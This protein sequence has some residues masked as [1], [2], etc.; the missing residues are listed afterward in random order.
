[1]RQEFLEYLRLDE[2]QRAQTRPPD[3]HVVAN[4]ELRQAIG[5]LFQQKCAFCESR[6]PKLTTYRFRPTSEALPL[7]R[8]PNN[9]L[10][11]GWLADA[12]QNLYLICTDCIP[13]PMN[14]FPVVGARCPIPDP[15]IYEEYVSENSGD[16]R[17]GIDEKPLLL[18]PC[19]DQDIRSH[20]EPAMDGT[21]VPQ[22]ARGEAMIAHFKLNRK[23]LVDRRRR[24]FEGLLRRMRGVRYRLPGPDDQFSGSLRVLRDMYME[25]T[26]LMGGGRQVPFRRVAEAP[27]VKAWN[28]QSVEIQSFKSLEHVRIDMPEQNPEN[29]KRDY[30][31]GGGALL[32]LGENATGKSSLLEALALAMLPDDARDALGERPE[33]IILDPRYLGNENKKA[34][35]RGHVSLAFED[36][37]GNSLKRQLSLTQDGFHSDGLLPKGFPV[38]GYGAY[39]QYR[40]GQRRWTADRRVVSLFR[41]DNLL[42]NPERWL[43]RLPEDRFDMVVQALRYIIGEDFKIIERDRAS[44][45]C[46][47]LM[48]RD[49]VELRMPLD[50]VSSGFRT[51]LALTCDVMR[52]LM[53]REPEF[54][55]LNAARG[56]VLIDEVEAHLHPRWKVAIMDGLRRALP[57]MTFIVT[58]HDPLCLRGMR[59]GEVLVLQ[60]VKGEAAG[61]SLPIMVETLTELPDVTKLTIEQLLT[62]DLFDLFDTDDPVT[63]RA[64]ADLAD[65]LALQRSGASVDE[66]YMQRLLKKFRGQIDGALPV[67]STEVSRLVQEAVAEFIINRLKLPKDGRRALREVTKKRIIK[68]LEEV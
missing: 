39:R 27:P 55:T 3:R 11:Y 35:Q 37:D 62:S 5:S 47:I 59:D 15:G 41:T 36:E 61:S 18:D 16:W 43:L 66:P 23:E 7:K 34:G 24:A 20:L 17:F 40:D 38:F 54:T 51:I 64:M 46:V 21:L 29:T 50:T 10:Y 2:K 67:G 6:T 26:I 14:H 9:H 13:R 65:V 45:R 19:T 63:G 28:L 53:E 12:W 56:L 33:K 30:G 48:D 8:E 57:N 4:L 68:A 42:S 1:M 32:I 52:W 25:N 22:S 49:G 44:R 60:R 31:E 58:T